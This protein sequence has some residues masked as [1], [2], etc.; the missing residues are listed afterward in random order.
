METFFQL[1][2]VDEEK[3]LVHGRFSQSI[4]DRSGE[5]MDW[6]TGRDAILSWSR[7]QSEA[8]NG[9]SLGNVRGQHQKNAAAGR[10]VSIDVVEDEKAIDGAV[11]VVDDQDWA[12]VQK[13]VYTGFSIGGGY[14]RRWTD[15]STGVAIKMYTPRV[16]EISLVDRPCVQ[17]AGFYEVVKCDGTTEQRGFSPQGDNM[18]EDAKAGESAE[19][20]K[21]LWDAKAL[22]SA[23]QELKS[24][25]GSIGE[26]GGIGPEL[27]DEVKRLG[28]L[29]LAYLAEELGEHIGLSVEDGV[30][31]D[32]I[33]GKAEETD[34]D[35]DENGELMDVAKG[36]F[37]GHPFRG[38]QYRKGGKAGAHHGASRSA[39][40]ATVRAHKAGGSSAHRAAANYH[41]IAS[42][43]HAKAGNSK[44]AAHHKEQAAYHSGTAARFAAHSKSVDG[45]LEKAARTGKKAAREQIA[46]SSEELHKLCKGYLDLYGKA[47]GDDEPEDDADKAVASDDLSNSAEPAPDMEEMI[48]RAVADAVRPFEGLLDKSAPAAA[49]PAT[50]AP[51]LRALDKD[52]DAS[53]SKADEHAELRKAAESDGP[54]AVRASIK[55][56]FTNPSIL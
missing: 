56:A 18:S 46:A 25:H 36:D 33:I 27:E 15:T 4:V 24:I 38:N 54:D 14:A 13:G 31:I 41:K 55:L 47:D 7:S 37:P 30:D 45:D 9:K 35:T 11:E 6:E 40:L 19:L 53:L 16:E 17:T 43:A 51:N 1:R 39:H 32:A 2:K 26:G 44:M 34:M 48:R 23:V 5:M 22:I 20:K 28:Q 8:S 42:S 3:R 49:S 10:I 21:G 50:R 29:A 52:A 12:K